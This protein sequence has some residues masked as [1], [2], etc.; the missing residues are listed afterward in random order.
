MATFL[1]YWNPYFS[2]YKLNRFL[3]D[4]NFPKGKDVFTDTDD[5]DHSPDY[6]NWSI[7]EHEKARKGD[8]FVFIRVGNKKPTGIIGIGT[9]TSDPY[10]DEDWSG[11]GRKIYYMDMRWESVVNP[12]SDK[13]LKTNVLI[14]AIPEVIWSKGKAGVEVAPEIATKIEDLWQNHLDSVK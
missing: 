10:V 14:D 4:F 5:W 6:F 2:S 3:N 13:V 12:T 11:Q 7:I 8:R 1:L 9:F